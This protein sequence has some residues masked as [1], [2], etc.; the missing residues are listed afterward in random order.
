M[1]LIV[2]VVNFDLFEDDGALKADIPYQS[3]REIADNPILSAERMAWFYTQ[4]LG[5][6]GS[7]QRKEIL[8]NQH[9]NI[10][11]HPNLSHLPPTAIASAEVDVLR[12]EGEALA[13]TLKKHKVPI[14][15]KRYMRVPHTFL[16]FGQDLVESAQVQ[17]D[18]LG[19]MQRALT[20]SRL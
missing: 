6:P 13:E 20:C 12:D 15:H 8:S 19:E 9:Y 4:Y 1:A 14:F 18:I 3:W 11:R 7:T 16:H 5:E 10:L 17:E 2:P